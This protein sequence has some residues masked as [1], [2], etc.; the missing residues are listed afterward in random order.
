MSDFPNAAA[1]IITGAW[2][3]GSAHCYTLCRLGRVCPITSA[4]Y[5]VGLPN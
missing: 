1:L 5:P 4:W 2:S 3:A